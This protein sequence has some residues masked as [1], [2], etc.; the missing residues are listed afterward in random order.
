MNVCIDINMYIVFGNVLYSDMYLRGRS[1][2]ANPYSLS[3][4]LS[5]SLSIHIYVC[6]YMYIYICIFLYMYI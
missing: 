3:L 1:R 6:I 4:S 2:Y 5:L